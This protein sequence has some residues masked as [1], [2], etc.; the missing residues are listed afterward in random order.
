MALDS[1]HFEGITRHAGRI[2]RDVDEADQQAF[3]ERV[4]QSFLDPL[5]NDDGQN[6][7]APLGDQQCYE[8]DIEAAALRES[9]YPTH[10]GLDSGTINPTSFKNG[11]VLDVAHAAMASEPSSMPLHRARTLVTTVHTTDPTNLHETD[12][13]LDEGY[14]RNL[15]VRAPTVGRFEE[16]VVHELSLY[17]AESE[18]ALRQFD[19]VDDLLVLDGPIYPKGILNWVDLS[20]TLEELLYDDDP[21]AVIENY[22]RL[23]ERADERDI[24]VVG[25]VKNTA[26]KAITRTLRER[27]ESAPWVNDAAFFTRLLERVEYAETVDDDG[28]TQRVRDRNTDALTYTNWF[29][30]RAGADRLLSAD[31]DAFGIERA[32]DPTAYEVT[33]F[34]LYDPREDLIYRIE[35]PYSVTNDPDRRRAITEF[36]LREVAANVGPPTAVQ[37]ADELARISREETTS[38]RNALAEEFE[39]DRVMTYDDHRWPDR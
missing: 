2:V 39:T 10:H 8:V 22:V 4:W 6:V 29:R 25:F 3:A 19:V 24:P 36:T 37:K 34:V 20:P 38:V 7:L 17:R 14:T 26:T 27:D 15:L 11:L 5:V 18:H 32:L 23:V 13:E 28:R 16:N 31:A 1:V 12:E 35:A 21:R 9:P 30:S 33:F